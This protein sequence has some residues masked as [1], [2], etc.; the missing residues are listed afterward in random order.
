[1]KKLIFKKPN[2]KK[3]RAKGYMLVDMHMHTNASSDCSTN[4]SSILKKAKT[5]GIGIAITDHNVI[6]SAIEAVDDKEGVLVI[7]AVEVNA[8]YGHHV[9]FYFYS[10][11]E[12]IRFYKNE[13]KKQIARKTPEELIDLKTKYNCV[14]GIAHP[15]GHEPWHRFKVNFNVNNLDCF[16]TINGSCSKQRAKIGASLAIKNN[17]GM[18]GGSDAHTIRKIGS[19]LTCVKAKTIKEFLDGIRANRTIV[20]GTTLKKIELLKQLPKTIIMLGFI[21]IE[22]IY[23]VTGLKKLIAGR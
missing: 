10:T 15:T 16:E 3:L 14:V 5:L 12:L 17:K 22:K 2:I 7:P 13:V 9:L 11:K 18:I 21:V 1:M 8:K 4:L 20:I 19:V 23:Q 6:D